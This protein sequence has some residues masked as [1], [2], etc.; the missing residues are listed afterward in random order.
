MNW[1]EIII[2]FLG[3]GL[4]SV[5]TIP[6]V[7]KKSRAEARAVELD[8]LQKSV[9]GWKALADERQEENREKNEHINAL[10]LKIDSM[11]EDIARRR[12]ENTDL[13][14][15]NTRLQVRIATDEVRMCMVRGCDRREPQ[16][17]Y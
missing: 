2:G 17:G 10:N 8:N 15:E 1:I 14:K 3:G 13:L 6:S 5:L 11:Y 16:S 12:T 7:L 4:V 9:E